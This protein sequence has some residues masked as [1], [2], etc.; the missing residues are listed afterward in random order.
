MADARPPQ[1]CGPT[2]DLYV[3]A[4]LVEGFELLQ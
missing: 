1:E 4:R 3:S 2:D